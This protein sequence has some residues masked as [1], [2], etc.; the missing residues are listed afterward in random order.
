MKVRFWKKEGVRFLLYFLFYLS[1]HLYM[2]GFGWLNDNLIFCGVALSLWGIYFVLNFF[3]YT[4]QIIEGHALFK[5]GI[6]IGVEKVRINDIAGIEPCLLNGDPIGLNLLL[7]NGKKQTI[8]TRYKPDE[9][10][11]VLQNAVA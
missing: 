5:N 9:V 1:W 2:D 10:Y 11:S 7:V 3:S 6:F 8:Y 4:L